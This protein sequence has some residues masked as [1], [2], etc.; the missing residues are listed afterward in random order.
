MIIPKDK[1]EKVYELLANKFNEEENLLPLDNYLRLA[2]KENKINIARMAPF[3][4]TVELTDIHESTIQVSENQDKR[5]ELTTTLC[6]IL[7][8]ELFI[9]SRPNAA[10]EILKILEEIAESCAYEISP[11]YIKRKATELLL[12]L[13]ADERLLKYKYK[14]NLV[15]QH[16]NPQQVLDE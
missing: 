15:G 2:E 16:D 7:R 4:T 13:A 3:T 5:I 11:L 14:P 9:N 12:K 10:G 6:T 8:Q 1:I